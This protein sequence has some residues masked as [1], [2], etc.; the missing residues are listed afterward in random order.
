MR[1]L[2]SASKLYAAFTLWPRQPDKRLFLL[3]FLVEQRHSRTMKAHGPLI[4]PND[5][6]AEIAEILALGLQRLRARKSSEL[7]HALGESS[8]D[9]PPAQSGGADI[10]SRME[11]DR[12]R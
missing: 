9:F 7:S 5:R 12:V 6:I 10:S 1:Q 2:R 3:Y 4:P 8:L 11:L